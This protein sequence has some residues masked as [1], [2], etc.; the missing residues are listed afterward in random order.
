MGIELLA[1]G[2]VGNFQVLHCQA[3]HIIHWDLEVHRHWSNLLSTLRSSSF[4]KGDLG[5]QAVLMASLKLPN[6][7][8]SH[9]LLWLV[10]EGLALNS[11]WELK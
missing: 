5:D 6:C 8:L 9:L 11:P 7:P 3:R 2:R 4:A 1:V 10:L